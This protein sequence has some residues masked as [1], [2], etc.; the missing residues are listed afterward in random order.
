MHAYVLVRKQIHMLCIMHAPCICS[1]LIQVL[2]A[3]P[4]APKK[5]RRLTRT[6]TIDTEL[7][8]ALIRTNKARRVKSE[9]FH[10]GT[11]CDRL[12]AEHLED[13]ARLGCHPHPVLVCIGSISWCPGVPAGTGGHSL[14]PGPSA[15]EGSLDLH[16]P[17][18]VH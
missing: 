4:M 10:D 7:A 2:I 5:R 8:N 3:A 6:P 17:L 16:F 11:L 9:W 14:G 18:L 12:V 15:L 1:G 13:F